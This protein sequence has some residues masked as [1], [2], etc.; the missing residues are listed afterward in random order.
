VSAVATG[1]LMKRTA[2]AVVVGVV[3][4]GAIGGC[5]ITIGSM[6]HGSSPAAGARVAVASSAAPSSPVW[7]SAAPSA[8]PPSTVSPSTSTAGATYLAIVEPANTATVALD[9]A[10]FDSPN[11]LTAVSLS[12]VIAASATSIQTFDDHL[13]SAT[14]PRTAEPDVTT[15]AATGDVLVVVLQGYESDLQSPTSGADFDT[16]LQ[17]LQVEDSAYA[18]DRGLASDAAGRVRADL[19][20]PPPSAPQVTLNT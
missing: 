6:G 1:E 12:S 10:V 2:F 19:G 5:S 13:R 14:W 9:S 3:V 4:V 11:D 15:L 7:Q 17:A 16:V 8:A 20:L 18:I